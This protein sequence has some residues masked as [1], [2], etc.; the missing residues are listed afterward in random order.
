MKYM[1]QQRLVSSLG[2]ANFRDFTQ[3]AMVVSNRC[4]GTI[5]KRPSVILDCLNFEDGIDR[6]SRNTGKELPFQAA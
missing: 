6:L 3:P 4:F 2:S 1:N 5:L